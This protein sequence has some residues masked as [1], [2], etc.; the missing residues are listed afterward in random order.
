MILHFSVII[1]I[2]DLSISIRDMSM[3]YKGWRITKLTRKTEGL[4]KNWW[5][6]RNQSLNRKSSKKVKSPSWPDLLWTSR[7]LNNDRDKSKDY[8]SNRRTKR[9]NNGSLIQGLR[10]ILVVSPTIDKKR[11]LSVTL[12]FAVSI[13][14]EAKVFCK[15]SST[16]KW[17]S[18]A[19][20]FLSYLNWQLAPNTKH[21][22]TKNPKNQ[23]PIDSK[24]TLSVKVFPSKSKWIS[25]FELTEGYSLNAPRWTY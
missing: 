3:L 13:P 22:K 10:K 8:L 19:R 17:K 5:K 7:L 18:A 1:K 16:T 24:C 2:T 14:K 15:T 25:K 4:W 9:W 12:T 11:R 21:S 20:T 23:T 6:S